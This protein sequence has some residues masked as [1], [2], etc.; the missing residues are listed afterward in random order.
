MPFMPDITTS[1]NTTSKRKGDVLDLGQRLLCVRRPNGLVLEL[2]EGLVRERPVVEV[3][4]DDEHAGAVPLRQRGR[5]TRMRRLDRGPGR[6]RQVDRERGA[7]SGLASDHDLAPRLLGEAEDLAQAEAGSLANALGREERLEDPVEHIHV[8]AGARVGDGHGDV[9][10]RHGGMGPHGRDAVR[11]PNDDIEEPVAVN[12]VP[13]IDHHVH[14]SGVELAR[15]GILHFE[16]VAT[17]LVPEGFDGRG[18]RDARAHK[19][20]NYFRHGGDV[21]SHVENLRQ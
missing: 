15:I 19:R 3:V 16:H 13:C 14:Q 5:L 7:A 8:D 2:G 17:G 6:P 20:P 18:Y 21:A 9:V 12:R 11:R 10:P 4:L 1:V